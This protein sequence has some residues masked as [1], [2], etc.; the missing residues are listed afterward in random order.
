MTTPV[1][2]RLLAVTALAALTGACSSLPSPTADQQA[3]QGQPGWAD[4]VYVSNLGTKG[5]TMVSNGT[6]GYFP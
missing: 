5:D 2:M 4:S 1:L 3:T 6:R